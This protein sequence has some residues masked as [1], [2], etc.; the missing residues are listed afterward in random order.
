M[1]LS[2]T[3]VKKASIAGVVATLIVGFGIYHYLSIERGPIY[4]FDSERDTA[5]IVSFARENWYWLSA[6]EDFSLPFSLKHRT[7]GNDRRYFGALKIKVIREDDQ[8]AGFT[9]YYM[10][11]KTR[12]QLLWLGVK[13]EFRGKGY[14][15]MLVSYAIEDMKKMGATK[16]IIWTRVSNIPA[17]KIY[18]RL[19]FV[20]RYSDDEGY[21][22]M[23]NDL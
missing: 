12:G 16:I 14:G 7:P 11:N 22:Y 1:E 20:E 5:S 13:P 10:H 2:R 9:A 19:G 21:L 18:T 23:E 6:L 15:D 17:V 8:F 4:D 3:A